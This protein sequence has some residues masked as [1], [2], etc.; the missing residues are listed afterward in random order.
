MPPPHKESPCGDLLML[1]LGAVLLVL[2]GW[3]ATE[4]VGWLSD[5]FGTDA[6]PPLK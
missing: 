6:P 1:L 4:L 2:V 5:S 3:G